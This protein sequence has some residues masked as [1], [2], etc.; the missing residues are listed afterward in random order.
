MFKFKNVDAGLLVLR[1]TVGGLLLLHGLRKVEKPDESMENLEKILTKND[2]PPAMSKGAYV[3]EVVAPI[4]MIA[5]YK[6]QTAASIVMFNMLMAVYTVNL[7]KIDKREKSGAWG[8]EV[9]GFYFFGSLALLL[10]GA[11][12]Y[13]ID[14]KQ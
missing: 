2:L 4:M 1:V 11:G 7:D 13:A 6:T 10:A 3:G 9:Q 12:K 5:G 8:L 14:K